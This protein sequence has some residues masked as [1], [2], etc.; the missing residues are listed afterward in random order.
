[1]E[2]TGQMKRRKMDRVRE[3]YRQ[4]SLVAMFVLFAFTLYRLVT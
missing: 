1:M 3:C 4:A 2:G